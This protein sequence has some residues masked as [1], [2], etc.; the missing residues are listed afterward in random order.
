MI[1]Y[2]PNWERIKAV[3]NPKEEWQPIFCYGAEIYNPFNVKITP[4]REV[5]EKVHSKQQGKNPEEWWNRYLQDKSF[6]LEEEVAAYGTQLVFAQ[7]YVRGKLL[8]WARDKMAE[9]LSEHYNLNITF[10]EARCKIKNS[11]GQ[12]NVP[13]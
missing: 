5:H 13:K 6:R 4:D 2:P 1:L 3:L 9:S 10:N 8:D 7:K 11:A 12:I